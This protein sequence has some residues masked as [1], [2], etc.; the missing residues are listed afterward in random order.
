M[1]GLTGVD[2][3]LFVYCLLL[4]LGLGVHS[5]WV[6]SMWANC[7]YVAA[8]FGPFPEQ[9]YCFETLFPAAAGVA[10]PR[11]PTFLIDIYCRSITLL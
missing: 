11:H 2:F 9:R 8:K 3:F 6:E 7:A 1:A 4:G 5:E 10:L